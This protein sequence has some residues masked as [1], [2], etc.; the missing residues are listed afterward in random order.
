MTM[1]IINCGSMHP[2][3]SGIFCGVSC[4]VVETNCGLVL[5]DTGFGM[6]DYL[7][8]TWLMRIFLRLIRSHRDT[9]E[10]AVKQIE[11]LGYQATDI[12]HIIMTHLHLDHAGGLPDFPHAKVHVYEPEYRHVAKRHFELTYNP[13]QWK[14][15]PNWVTHQV[16]GKWYD[17]DA[18]KLE[19][20][21][22]EIWLV[23]LTG[24][25]IGHSAVAVRTDN[26]W[27][28]HSG[29]AVPFNMAIKKIPDR[30]LKLAFG[31]HIPRVRE[32]MKKHPEVQVIGA[33]MPVDFYQLKGK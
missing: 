16:S 7:H 32:F 33:H 25:T 11:R 28:M 27:I 4:L 21:I 10:T 22:P 8:P 18:V 31:P 1:R 12:Q 17:F 6:Q 3:L 29:D 26:S 9:N 5:V 15:S 30:I 24:H 20:F 2:V 23:P 19:P 14:H 13:S